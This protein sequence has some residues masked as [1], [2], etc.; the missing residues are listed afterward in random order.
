MIIHVYY[1]PGVMTDL[2]YHTGENKSTRTSKDIILE[3]HVTMSIL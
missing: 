3:I 2:Y 1:Y